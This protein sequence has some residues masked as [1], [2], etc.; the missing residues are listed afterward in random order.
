MGSLGHA[1]FEKRPKC[2]RKIQQV[3]VHLA[4]SVH[5]WCLRES[6]GVNLGFR[7]EGFRGLGF[8]VEVEGFEVNGLRV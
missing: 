3:A 4:E 2:N 7:V 1:D 8:K 5:Y 6:G